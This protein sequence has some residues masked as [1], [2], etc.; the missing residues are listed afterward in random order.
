MLDSCGPLGLTD[1]SP[2][3]GDLSMDSRDGSCFSGPW[4]PSPG[5]TDPDT[6]LLTQET[7]T[8]ELFKKFNKAA[9]LA[10]GRPI[11]SAHA[12][13]HPIYSGRLES[14]LEASSPHS[15]EI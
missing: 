14:L 9:W 11:R 10:P 3:V 8:C 4:A 5:I 1:S 7:N 2:R 15:Q 12:P 13:P 6:A